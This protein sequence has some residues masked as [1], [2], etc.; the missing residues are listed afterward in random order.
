VKR[1][2]NVVFEGSIPENYDRYLGPTLFESFADDIVARLRGAR[3]K[4]LLETACGTGI[5]TGKVRDAFPD[6]R[7]VATDLNPGMLEFA[8]SKFLPNKNVEW[9]EA[10]ASALPFPGG[11]FDA[12]VCQFGLMFVPNKEMA[13]REAYRVLGRGGVFLF[14]VWDS[15][16]Q[17]PFAQ[18]AHATIG[19]FFDVDPPNFYEIPFSFYNVELIGILLETAGFKSIET[20]LVKLPCRSNS[21]AD[22]AAG[23][24]RG[25]PVATAIQE[26]GVE[27]EKVVDAVKETVAKRLGSAPVESTMQAYVW[28]ARHG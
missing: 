18:I 2:S 23:L 12:V 16:A 6:A 26:R 22:F 5:L 8:Q 17:N 11:A 25:N 19:S 7:I 1:D 15:M 10:D 14:N 24:V 20:S 4:S 27:L 21:A 28:R 9:R 13:V 3:P